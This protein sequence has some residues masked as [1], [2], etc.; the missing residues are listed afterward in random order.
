MKIPF[1]ATLAAASL[2]MAATL[3]DTR[4]DVEIPPAEYARVN[5]DLLEH[6]V[7][8]R[9]EHLADAA[10]AFAASAAAFCT[11]GQGVDLSTVRERYHDIMD[12]WM[13][14]Q[15]IDFGPVELLMRSFRLYF[16][17]GSRGKVAD[18]LHSLTS[19]GLDEALSKEKFSAA[20]V[21][22]QGL[23]AA[24]YL[25]YEAFDAKTAEAAGTPQCAT[26]TAIGNNLES[27]AAGIVADWRGG[28]MGFANAF[29]NPGA[30]NIHYDS[31][32]SATLELFKSLHGGLET[33][34]DVRLGPAAGESVDTARPALAESRA[35]DRA[36]RNIVIILEAL[37][38]LYLGDGGAGLSEM[39]VNHGGDDKLDPLMR[40]AFRLTTESARA[41]EPP[42]EEA[43]ADAGRR[44]AVDTLLTRVRAL[45]Q[46]TG[47]RVA[48]ALGVAVGFNARDGD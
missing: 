3:S 35:S 27:M 45:A 28:N 8:P 46:I 39:V 2:V 11:G 41:V 15:H 34:A 32:R 42:L 20:S 12:A 9:Y 6:H 7:L 29:L 43:V 21:A 18:A 10:S 38:A 36:L 1:P 37:E 40:K 4:A 31:H 33:V 19:E 48:P 22:V 25:L 14:V 13:A 17:P 44:P 47:E 26:L 24:E 5:A 16:W 30:D 23:P